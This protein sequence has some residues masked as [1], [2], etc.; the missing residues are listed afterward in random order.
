MKL[1]AL[2]SKPNQEDLFNLHPDAFIILESDGTV[3]DVNIKAVQIFGFS[4]FSMVDQPI[5]QYIQGGTNQL[6]IIVNQDKTLVLKAFTAAKDERYIEISASQDPDTRKVYLAIRDVTKTYKTQ[7]NTNSEFEAAKAIIAEKNTYLTANSNEILSFISSIG[8]FSKAL[9]D[10]VGGELESKQEKYVSIINKN[11]K[12]L[13]YDLEKMFEMFRL[14]SDLWEY[15]QK[16]FDVVNLLSDLAKRWEDA[17]RHKK[18]RFS[19]DFSGIVSRNCYTDPAVLEK[20]VNSLIE[21]SYRNTDVGMCSLNVGVAP[22]EF[23]RQ[24]GFELDEETQK[25]KYYLMFEIKDTSSAIV[26][27]ELK[28]IFNPYYIIKNPQKRPMGSKFTYAMVKKF[29]KHF[30][31]DLWVYSKATQGTLA[32]FILPLEKLIQKI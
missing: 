3:V 5:S 30:G 20:I 7:N 8:S 31:G 13:A 29:V 24:Q 21:V 6:N 28:N 16:T 9:L 25:T 15:N 11:A 4:R 10:G 32:S 23:L 2:F 18:V 19:Y 17:F 26:D 1:K 12:D 14:E 22:E 27:E